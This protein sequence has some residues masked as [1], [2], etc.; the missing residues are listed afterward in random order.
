MG[1]GP[2]SGQAWRDRANAKAPKPAAGTEK[3]K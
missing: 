2:V 3:K 1:D